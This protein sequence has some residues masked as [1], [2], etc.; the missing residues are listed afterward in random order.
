MAKQRTIN[1]VYKVNKKEIDSATASTKKIQ[2][3]T[4][5]LKK[6]LKETES[7]G[8]KAFNAIGAA[9]LAVGI[10][11]L[12]KDILRLGAAQQ[13]LNIAFTTF[14]GDANKAKKLIA[15]L[16]KF[17]IVTPFTPEQVNK[18]AK[19]LLAFGVQSKDIIRTLKFLG[20][21]SAG[22]GKDLAEMA[23]IFGQIRST[24]RLMGQDLLQLINAGFNPLQVISEKTGKSV[25]KL[26]KEMEEG[27]ISFKDVEGAFIA[28]TSAG[29]LFFNLMEK[30]S[31]SIAGKWSTIMGNI[32]E[33]GKELFNSNVLLVDLLVSK[34]NE[35]TSAFLDVLKVANSDPIFERA[36]KNVESFTTSLDENGKS[37]DK[38]EEALDAIS[39]TGNSDAATQLYKDLTVAVNEYRESIKFLREEQ[40]SETNTDQF[41][42][43]EQI[44][45]SEAMTVN[46]LTDVRDKLRKDAFAA[47]EKFELEESEK[48]KAINKSA[49]DEELT[50]FAE[51][52]KLRDEL[53][54][55]NEK[56]F[57]D[58]ID[59]SNK[60][61]E[62]KLKDKYDWELSEL[63]RKNEREL[64]AQEE[65]NAKKKEA[66]KAHQ[67]YIN[68]LKKAAFN[69]GVDLL[70][71]ALFAATDTSTKE[72]EAVQASYDRQIAAAGDNT[73]RV[74]ELRAEQDR[75]ARESAIRQAK[76]DQQKQI[77]QM[78]IQN[79]L[80]VLRAI[81]TPPVPNFPLAGITAGYGLA[82]INIAKAIGFKEG[83]IDLKGAG[84]ATSDSIPARLSKGE[85]VMTAEE[86]RKSMGILKDIR[87]KKLD[88][89]IFENLKVTGGSVV[90]NLDDRR[91]VSAIEKSQIN[92]SREG[93]TLYEHRRISETLTRKIR[94]K[95]ITR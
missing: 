47:R 28:A 17:S 45:K 7:V 94:A 62:Q 33:A 8:T 20:D 91:I 22:T 60:T 73:R 87:A 52:Y 16:T 78:I 81:G 76:L 85:S 68:D 74:N 64:K 11:S 29:G 12:V 2:G 55:R 53:Q 57:I 66:E 27:L 65:A 48:L 34:L 32:E 5:K 56:A 42:A 4:Q 95:I 50:I 80:N 24:G 10:G 1:I 86:T 36:Q 41:L 71:E 26:K 44:I 70:G 72:A 30:Q 37:I 21:V 49:R 84:T 51:Y 35:Y 9:I 39:K 6:E 89:K 67:D 23:V 69:Y 92:L 77:K 25:A 15:E 46:M 90:A 13:Q 75:A 82:S 38:V 83:V 59:E 3:E 54:K 19:S 58:T 93:S 40:D 63:M 88:D 18:A 14:L 61:Q 43:R 31:A 79:L